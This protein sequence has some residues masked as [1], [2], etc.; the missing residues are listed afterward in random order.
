M[1]AS[2]KPDISTENQK[3]KKAMSLAKV[4][5]ASVVLLKTEDIHVG[6]VD[7]D[8]VGPGRLEPP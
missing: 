8:D 7:G 1:P 4:C 5:E 6:G 2:E 3:T